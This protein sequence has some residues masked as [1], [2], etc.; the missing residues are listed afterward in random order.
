MPHRALALYYWP[1]RPL[2][3]RVIP[4]AWLDEVGHREQIVLYVSEDR[5]LRNWTRQV[6]AR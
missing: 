5:S 2:M 1:P 6:S 4:E 3:G